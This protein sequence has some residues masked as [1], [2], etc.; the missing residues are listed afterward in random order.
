METINARSESLTYRSYKLIRI[1]ISWH[2][3]ST[4]VTETNNSKSQSLR[5][6]Q[7]EIAEIGPNE[8]TQAANRMLIS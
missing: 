7:R 4:P 1:G 5:L 6:L 2:S 8:R 3:T